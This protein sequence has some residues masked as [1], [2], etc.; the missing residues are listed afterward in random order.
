ML[1]LTS[2]SVGI[3]YYPEVFAELSIKSNHDLTLYLGL[4]QQKA[5]NL[6]QQ[7]LTYLIGRSNLANSQFI[8]KSANVLDELAKSLNVERV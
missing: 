4:D 8:D 5:F 3:S 6:T 7:L 1:K 2:S